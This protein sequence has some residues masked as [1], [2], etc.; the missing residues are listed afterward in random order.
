MEFSS[1]VF[2]FI[3]LPILLVIY[4]C[5]LIKSI[6]VRNII[7]LIA[8]LL[9]YAYGEPIYIL[10][11]LGS[12]LVNYF[13]GIL[14]DKNRNS[15]R[16]KKLY[17]VIGIIFNVLLIVCF[18]YL[19]FIFDNLSLL[20][21]KELLAYDIALPIGISFYTFSILSYL[22]DV[23]RGDAKVQKNILNVALYVS[24]FPKLIQ[25]P[26]VRYNDIAGELTDRKTSSKDI[27]NGIIRFVIGLAKKV[28][29]S[30]YVAVIAD[31]CFMTEDLSVGLAWLGAIAYTFQIYFDFS[32]YSDMAIGLGKIFG[33]HF[34]ENFNYPYISGSITEFWRR[35]H[36][37]LGLWFRNYVYIPLGGNRVKK[38]RLILNLLVVWLLTGIWH[39]ANWT[40]VIW[41]LI[42]FVLLV[43]EKFTNLHKNEKFTKTIGHVYTLL[44]VIIGWVFFRS[45]DLTSAISYL[46]KMFGIGANGL[47]GGALI[48]YLKESWFVLLLCIVSCLPIKNIIEKFI[49]NRIKKINK[50][51]ISILLSIFLCVIFILSISIC[52]STT[53]NPS[54]YFNF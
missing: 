23:Y 7:L 20:F 34:A 43:I 18:K 28:I 5:K 37:S 12:I 10:V 26:I 15:N 3:F 47:V 24:L 33:F 14:I 39:G 29:L 1:T 45:T 4:H 53:Y 30:N 38:P 49:Q 46:G 11:M 13:I 6:K 27:T 51:V 41:G 19:N 25:G 42:Y 16:T 8:S 40:F 54:I 44:F 52:V 50:N 9:F 17:L 35:W 21:N 48:E 2:L 31:N 36:I 22:I 32:G